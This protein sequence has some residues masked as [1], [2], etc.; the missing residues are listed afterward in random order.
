MKRA[1]ILPAIAV[2]LML[3]ACDNPPTEPD[4]ELPA[5]ASEVTILAGPVTGTFTLRVGHAESGP[6]PG[7]LATFVDPDWAINPSVATRYCVR[8]D[9]AGY[10]AGATKKGE[11]ITQ[12]CISKST[13]NH[14]S[15]AE[16]ANKTASWKTY[17]K[18]TVG[19]SNLAAIANNSIDIDSAE[20][21]RLIF[22]GKGCGIKN[23]TFGPF[24][25]IRPVG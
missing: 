10:P 1:L 12:Y 18:L 11:V 7:T 9:I 4:L 21:W 16:C 8:L 15:K 19:V 24:D 5:V 2:G 14:V 23:A 3:W 22:R 17:S 20:G 13:G 6:C 25:V